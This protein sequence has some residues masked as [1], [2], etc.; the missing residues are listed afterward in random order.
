MAMP[1]E[2]AATGACPA[3]VDEDGPEHMGA[4]RPQQQRRF[5]APKPTDPTCD[6]CLRGKMKKLGKYVGTF[7]RPTTQF[8]DSITMGRCQF[9]HSRT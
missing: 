5:L 9:H 3:S 1:Q 8:G 4:G 2:A 6:S 7:I